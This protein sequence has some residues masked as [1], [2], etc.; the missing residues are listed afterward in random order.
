LDT[1]RDFQGSGSMDQFGLVQA[2]NGFGQGIIVTVA[3]TAQRW[4]RASLRSV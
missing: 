4:T 3:L 2:V 1:T